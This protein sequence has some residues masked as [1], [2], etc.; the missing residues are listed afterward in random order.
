MTDAGWSRRRFLGATAGVV[1]FA[2][3]ASLG[4]VLF[5]AVRARAAEIR[6][7]DLG[8]LFLLQGA[9]ANV[10]ALGG[11]DG[12]L[13]VDGGLA[14]HAEAL[15]AAVFEATGN[16]RVHT[17]INTHW[18]PEQTGANELVGR[19]GGVILAHEKTRM[20]LSHLW[21][22]GTYERIE[23][24]PEAARPNKVT[25]GDGSLEFAGQ[26][27]DY[28]YLPQAHTDGDLYVHFP[29][30]DVVAVGGVLSAERWPL[31]DYRNGSWYGG[32]VRA[33]QWLAEL[34][35]PDTQVVPADGRVM[36]GREVVRHRDIHL[37]LFETMIGYMNMGLGYEDVVELNP[38][39]EYEA[40]F[41]DASAFLDGAYRS[42]T[43]A[44]VPE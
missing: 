15:L 37:A 34:V 3:A 32:R 33:L 20:Y 5:P 43:I 10:L 18:H 12:A 29:E 23:P 8:G 28:G 7:T 26:R 22:S 36:T 41:G 14:E 2:G 31:I 40:E 19:A 4:S 38:L 30:L 9:G 17:L 21:Y 11:P 1:R 6:T 24:L 35:G 42:M 39:E 16:D 25:R 27:V 13:M 44:Y